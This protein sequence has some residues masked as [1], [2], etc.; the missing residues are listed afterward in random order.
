MS[1]GF[2]P[3]NGASNPFGFEQVTNLWTLGL[4]SSADAFRIF[5]DSTTATATKMAEKRSFEG[6]IPGLDKTREYWTKSLGQIGLLQQQIFAEMLVDTPKASRARLDAQTFGQL[7][8]LAGA[9]WEEETRRLSEVPLELGE[10]WLRADPKQLGEL[11]ASMTKEYLGDLEMLKGAGTKIDLAPLA[12]AW[13][14]LALGKEDPEAQQIV[15]RF[16]KVLATKAELGPEYYADPKET[17]VGQ[18]PRELVLEVGGHRLYRYL[19]PADAEERRGDP[20]LLVYSVINK[21]YILDLVP[22]Y[23]F[24]EHLVSQG[25][26]VYLI[27]WAESEPGDRETT[28]DSYIEPGIDDCVHYIKDRTGSEKVSLFGHCIGGNLAMLYASLHPEEVS[29]LITLTTP[30]TASKG[31]VVAL[32]THK[33]LLPIDSIIDTFGHMPAKLI[34]YTFMALKPYFEV[35]KWK[36][37]VENLGN[38]A[39]MSLFHPVDRWANENVDIPGEVF[40]KLI[41]EVFHEDRF[42]KGK[43]RINGRLADP[44][45]IDCPFL[46]LAADGDWIVSAESAQVLNEAVSSE[47][48]RFSMISGPHVAI[49]MDPRT[50]PQ[51]VEMSDFL[52]EKV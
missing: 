21:A 2:A 47:D 29:K 23:S 33:D 39:M 46:N 9:R 15:D 49:M 10:R 17:V 27:E 12:K 42:R 45:A 28:L 22:G 8:R 40:R 25:L 37:Y 20:V 14:K 30:G 32:W 24:I 16:L 5:V 4:K 26:D 41:I 34:R 50:H 1:N 35:L 51:W 18:S 44:G 3:K 7:Q 13:G 48:S 6:S 11:C 19:P 36:M 31:G 52:L 38:D 43:T